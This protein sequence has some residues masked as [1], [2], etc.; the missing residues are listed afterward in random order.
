MAL[1]K[2]KCIQCHDNS[3]KSPKGFPLFCSRQ[4]MINRLR[5]QHMDFALCNQCGQWFDRRYECSNNDCPSNLEPAKA[6][7]GETP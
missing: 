4:C 5:E 2:P 6:A 3:A 1:S 7:P